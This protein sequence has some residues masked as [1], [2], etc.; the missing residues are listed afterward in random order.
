VVSANYT[1]ID[2]ATKLAALEKYSATLLP[3]SIEGI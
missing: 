3:V 2:E 1:H